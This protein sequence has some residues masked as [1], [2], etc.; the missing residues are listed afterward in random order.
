[1]SGEIEITHCDHNLHSPE[2][3]QLSG[4]CWPAPTEVTVGN[5]RVLTSAPK[6]DVNNKP[7]THEKAE[8][9][10]FVCVGSPVVMFPATSRQSQ[11]TIR[12]L[13]ATANCLTDTDTST[14]LSHRCPNG[15]P[16]VR[17]R[18]CIALVVA[19]SVGLALMSLI[20]AL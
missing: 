2:P 11:M 7:A 18:S 8:K 12:S 1:M 19:L 20:A 5:I 17:D 6:L 9:N 15:W 3:D 14:I 13:V 10:I 16:L 4:L